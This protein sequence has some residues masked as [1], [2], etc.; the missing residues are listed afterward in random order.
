MERPYAKNIA[1]IQ[2]NVASRLK[3]NDLTIQTLAKHLQNEEITSYKSAKKGGNKVSPDINAMTASLNTRVKLTQ[4]IQRI[5]QQSVQLPDALAH[6]H[7]E[8]IVS[9][10]DRAL[11]SQLIAYDLMMEGM[12]KVSCGDCVKCV[13]C[14]CGDGRGGMVILPAAAAANTPCTPVPHLHGPTTQLDL[15]L[16]VGEGDVPPGP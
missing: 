3:S 1:V 7:L 5:Q 10:L 12:K 9:R 11:N 4:E 16:V 14:G 8:F 2:S 13:R 15:Q 6:E